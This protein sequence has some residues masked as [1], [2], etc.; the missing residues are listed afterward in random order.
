MKR[1]FIFTQVFSHKKDDSL[2]EDISM[3]KAVFITLLTLTMVQVLSDQIS[4]VKFSVTDSG[5]NVESRVLQS[6][7]EAPM[8][9]PLYAQVKKTSFLWLGKSILGPFVSLFHRKLYKRVKE[10]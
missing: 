6:K 1:W 4:H 2:G 5:I 8:A 3:A 9:F 10:F 7:L